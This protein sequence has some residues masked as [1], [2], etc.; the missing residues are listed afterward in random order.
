MPPLVMNFIACAFFLDWERDDPER[1]EAH[2]EF[3]TALVHEFSNMYGTE[4]DSIKSWRGLCLALEIVPLP[5]RI[6]EA[7]KVCVIDVIP[8]SI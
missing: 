3:K 8:R 7:K 4:V 5:D 6:N 1:E 2:E